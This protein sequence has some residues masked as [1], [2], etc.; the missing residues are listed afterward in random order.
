M[1]AGCRSRR[2]GRAPR[3]APVARS[4]REID[5][6]PWFCAGT[7]V[8]KAANHWQATAPR[9]AHVAPRPPLLQ[10]RGGLTTSFTTPAKAIP[11]SP[12]SPIRQ[13]VNPSISQSPNPLNSKP[14]Q[15]NNTNN[16][17]NQTIPIR[18]PNSFPAPS[19]TAP[20]R[21]HENKT[22]GISAAGF[23]YL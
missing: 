16:A 3:R 17:N 20:R 6:A 11:K 9:R 19:E 18:P 14:K 5:V 4:G 2:F 8:S 1:L 13:S 15:S 21:A 12:N 10:C 23:V 7:C 22:R